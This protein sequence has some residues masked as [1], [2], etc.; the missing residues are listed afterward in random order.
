MAENE[1]W[2]RKKRDKGVS[3]RPEWDIL[4]G[5]C[6]FIFAVRSSRR[7]ITSRRWTFTL[8]PY[9]STPISSR[10]LLLCY[11]SPVRLGSFRMIGCVALSLSCY[12]MNIQFRGLSL[13]IISPWVFVGTSSFYCFKE[14][15]CIRKNVSLIVLCV[16]D[17]M[18][19][20][21]GL[22]WVVY[23][24]LFIVEQFYPP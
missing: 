13:E 9:D 10:I 12:V 24:S 8:T 20:E 2:S 22:K 21:G 7:E 18:P 17:V 5:M 14:V 6:V 19:K 4:K 11:K 16:R 3:A 15:P 1:R 23:G